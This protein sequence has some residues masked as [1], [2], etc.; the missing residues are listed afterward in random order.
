MGNTEATAMLYPYL[1][2]NGKWLNLNADHTPF[3]AKNVSC[4]KLQKF[5]Q[6]FMDYADCNVIKRIGKITLHGY[7]M[8]SEQLT[9]V[10]FLFQHL[11]DLKEIHVEV[12]D[13][14]GEM[15][16]QIDTWKSEWG[17]QVS[18]GKDGVLHASRG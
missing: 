12:H 6:K 10:P 8:T 2:D 7:D 17:L 1:Y 13:P 3:L 11:P 16:Q 9:L 4:K 5:A 14:S 18:L 15:A